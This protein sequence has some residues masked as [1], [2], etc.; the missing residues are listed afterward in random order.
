MEAGALLTL[1]GLCALLRAAR[2][3]RLI[4]Q[5]ARVVQDALLD[6]RKSGKQLAAEGGWDTASLSRQ[7]HDHGLNFAGLFT[8]LRQDRQFAIAFV[9]RLCLA[10]GIEASEV[11]PG[12]APDLSAIV[13]RVQQLELQLATRRTG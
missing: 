13:A 7:L 5:S 4:E 12:V 1:A 11:A 10:L 3:A 9:K 8:A 2:P 6:C